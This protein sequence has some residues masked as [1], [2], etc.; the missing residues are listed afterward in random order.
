M[1]KKEFAKLKTARFIGAIQLLGLLIS[2]SSIFFAIWSDGY[3]VKVFLTG[4]AIT[5]ISYIFYEGLKN[6]FN[7]K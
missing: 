4:V 3:A 7:V 2:V 5:F 6:V 1:D